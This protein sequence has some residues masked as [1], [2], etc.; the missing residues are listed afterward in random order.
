[1]K[2]FT[3]KMIFIWL[4]THFLLPFLILF[5]GENNKGLEI[6]SMLIP[7]LIKYWFLLFVSGAIASFIMF[8]IHSGVNYLI[9]VNRKIEGSIWIFLVYWISGLLII[10]LYEYVFSGKI[11]GADDFTGVNTT[12]ARWIAFTIAVVVFIVLDR[13]KRIYN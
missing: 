5:M 4:G 6:D 1:M 11:L 2:E 10:A 8:F 12:V 3:S 13:R 7:S 9:L